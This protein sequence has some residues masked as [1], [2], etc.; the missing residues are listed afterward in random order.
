MAYIGYSM[1]NTEMLSLLSSQ[2]RYSDIVKPYIAMMPVFY[3][4][5]ANNISPILIILQ[6]LY[7][8]LRSAEAPLLALGQFGKSV[9]KL[10]QSSTICFKLFSL[11]TGIQDNC[12][13]LVN[14]TEIF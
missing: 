2:P 14:I 6:Y 7:N 1:G 5:N 8:Y 11:F 10:C 9:A 4:D 3:L 12:C 13:N